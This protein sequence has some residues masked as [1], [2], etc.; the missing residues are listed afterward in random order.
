MGSL[1]QMS[2]LRS[3]CVGLSIACLLS[4][5]ASQPP[6]V[7]SFGIYATS[8]AERI[9]RGRYLVYGPAHCAECHGADLSGGRTFPLNGLLGKV[10]ASNLTDDPVAGI[11]AVSDDMLVQALRY[12]VSRHGRPML[13]F[14]L[15][16]DLTD[17]DLQAVISFLRTVPAVQGEATEDGLNF[18]GR[19]A[20]RRLLPRAGPIERPREHINPARTVEFGAYMA[21]AVAGC[22]GCHTL[23]RWDGALI[24]SPYAGGTQ[25]R[26]EGETFVAPN[27][28]V[29]ASGVLNHDEEDD[30]IA[31]FRRVDVSK[32]RS[33]M[34][35]RAYSRMS[36][37]ELA[38][39]YL[40]L[41]SLP[42]A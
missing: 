36:D 37:T 41:R 5:C 3:A 16:F 28:T 9:E 39:I 20:V 1:P 35:W 11:G 27:L 26:A 23:R 8:Q 33:P 14:M 17:D 29:G 25:I 12:G 15:Y 18:L 7:P 13:P 21:N 30:F 4:G 34:P 42:A 6:I 32:Q 24:G 40:Y 2:P 19:F 38:A 10:S 22:R 31:R